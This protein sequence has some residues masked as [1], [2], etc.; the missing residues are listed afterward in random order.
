MMSAIKTIVIS[1][2]YWTFAVLIVVTIRFVGLEFI[3]ET[4]VDISLQEIY[5]INIP[6]G[7][8]AGLFWG[9]LEIAD[10]KIKVKKRKSF[11]FVVLSKTMVYI[12]IF[13]IVTFFASWIGSGSLDMAK[14][15][16]LSEVLIG[17]FVFF[18]IASLLFHFFKQMNRKFGPGILKQYLTGKYFNP[19]EENRIFM[20]LDLKSS[21]SIA[22]KLSHVLYSKL[23]QDCFR[24]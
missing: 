13:L 15:F 7:L 1:M 4:P 10:N 6:G 19:I 18:I 2:I 24:K 20:F 23:I 3:L 17:N 21:T 12:I 14:K 11:G 9:L 5:F 22:E 8:L 16:T